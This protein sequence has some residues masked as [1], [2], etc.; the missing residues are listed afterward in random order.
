MNRD[1]VPITGEIFD[2]LSIYMYD[3][4]GEVAWPKYL[5]EFI[6]MLHEED[7]GSHE[8]ASLLLAHT[9]RESPCRWLLSLL[10][11]SM[12]SLEH[13]CDLIE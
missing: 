11:N 4:K 8:H 7:G 13:F 12:H 6:S 1:D 3:G 5:H 9:L 2:L 10:A